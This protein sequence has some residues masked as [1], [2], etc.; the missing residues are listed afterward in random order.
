MTGRS[1]EEYSYREKSWCAGSR[2]IEATTRLEPISPLESIPPLRKQNCKSLIQ[3]ANKKGDIMKDALNRLKRPMKRRS[4]I[5]EGMATAGTVAS[6]TGLLGTAS[7]AFGQSDKK[8][9]KG[10]AAIL[11]FLAAAEILESDLW[12]QYWELSS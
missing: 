4:F 12:E 2:A 3:I 7:A 5:K 8:L 1:S 11:S 10:D 6:A 9:S